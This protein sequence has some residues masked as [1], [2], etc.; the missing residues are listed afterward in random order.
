MFSYDDTPVRQE[1]LARG[2]DHCSSAGDVYDLRDLVSGDVITSPRAPQ[3]TAATAGTS[4]A[5]E[6]V[7]IYAVDVNFNIHI[8]FDG[9]RGRPNAVK[10][11]TLFH[12]AD[13]RAAG[14]LTITDGIIV[15]VNDRS[16]SYRTAR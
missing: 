5:A 1:R 13:V 16:G 7:L 3:R 4:A 14:E 9:V 6:P 15:G 8:A 10:H 12:N 2:T 11:E